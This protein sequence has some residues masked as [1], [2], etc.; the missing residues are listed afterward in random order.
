M[1]R[2]LILLLA[3]VMV[4]S[5]ALTACEGSKNPTGNPTPNPTE[6]KKPDASQTPGAPRTDLNLRLFAEPTTLDPQYSTS[7]YDMAVI[8]QIFDNL[9]EIGPGGYDDLQYSLCTGYEMNETATEF[10]FH[11]REGVHFSN[12]D[13]LTADDVAFSIQRMVESPVTSNRVNFITNVEKVDDYTVKCT[14]S[15]PCTRLP[16]LL[17][18]ATMTIVNKK[19]VEQYG[20]N[21]PE[22]LVGTGAYKLESWTPGQGIVLTAFEEGWRGSPAIKTLNYMIIPDQTASRVRFQNGELDIYYAVSAEDFELFYN[23]EGLTTYGYSLS[24]VTVMAM[25]T[26]RPNLNNLKIRQAIAHAINSS[27]VALAVS[28]GLWKT[29]I[30]LIPESAQGFTTDV[31]TYDYN[32]E[33]AKQLLAEAGYNGEPIKL[34]YTSGI[35]VTESWATTIE[36]FLRASGINVT[37]EGQES[38]TVIQRVTDGDFDLCMFEY[39]TSLAHPVSSFYALFHS[40]GYYNVFRYNN[41]EIDQKII[42]AYG[43]ADMEAQRK[44]LEDINIEISKECLYVP[45]YSGSG[46]YFAPSNL[47]RNANTEPAF[48][49]I[50]LCYATWEN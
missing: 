22:M 50:K 20:T 5:L 36:A 29:A 9:F 17:S 38:A 6:S 48:G 33:K 3:L 19:L 34:L 8:Y 44:M 13:L 18:T 45:C 37:M 14:L 2:K 43:S 25:N 40:T 28:G 11:I 26:S 23:K 27:D 12:G 41:P 42:A 1:K 7:V 46:A 35:A 47:N 10:V 39:G 49:W 24:T 16:Q 32:P 21:S 30:S 15:I 31:V 4:L